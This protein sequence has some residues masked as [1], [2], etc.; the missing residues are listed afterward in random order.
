MLREKLGNQRTKLIRR[1]ISTA[2][3]FRDPSLLGVFTSYLPQWYY[4]HHYI[5]GLKGYGEIRV[6]RRGSSWATPKHLQQTMT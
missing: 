6:I 2:N 1:V 4:V 3:N 5:P